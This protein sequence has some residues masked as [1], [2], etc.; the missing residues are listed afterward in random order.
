MFKGNGGNKTVFKVSAGKEKRLNN[1]I[2]VSHI[3]DLKGVSLY[4]VFAEGK[5][6]VSKNPDYSLLSNNCRL[7]CIW[8]ES[9][10]SD[11]PDL[12]S[13]SRILKVESIV[14]I[15]AS[16]S[17]ISDNIAEISIAKYKEA[18]QDENSYDNFQSKLPG[19]Q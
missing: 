5:S 9:R 12:F 3:A 6:F 1:A 14:S 17:V 2:T 15:E 4:D 19:L 18:F 8:V 11:R 13:Y 7:F 16:F 10:L